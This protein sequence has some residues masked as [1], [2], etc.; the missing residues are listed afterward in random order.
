LI[1]IV[2]GGVVVGVVAVVIVGKNVV[3]IVVGT[4]VVLVNDSV[5]VVVVCDA[6]V[7]V[8][9]P[10][11]HVVLHFS[12]AVH[13]S[14]GTGQSKQLFSAIFLIR[15]HID[16]FRFTKSSGT[17]PRKLFPKVRIDVNAV[18]KVIS[19]GMEPP[20]PVSRISNARRFRNRPISVPITPLRHGLLLN[21]IDS[22]FPELSQIIGETTFGPT[23]QS[24]SLVSGSLF[25]QR[26]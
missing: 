24:V 25:G 4:V 6:V 7:S 20:I 18:H 3:V 8:S 5:N 23:S 14:F 1:S 11:M 22:G 9:F 13:G 19:C 17:L 12:V 21:K 2:V 16:R 26:L 15:V 10:L